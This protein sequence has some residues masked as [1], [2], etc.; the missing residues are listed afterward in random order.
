MKTDKH[1]KMLDWP[2]F[3]NSM[4]IFGNT[5]FG[6]SEVHTVGRFMRL[7]LG[8]NCELELYMWEHIIGSCCHSIK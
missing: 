3:S 4:N 5:E 1:C 6:L 7:C 8:E 2:L